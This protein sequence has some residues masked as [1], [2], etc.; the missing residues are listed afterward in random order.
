[1][2]TLKA[3]AR[4]NRGLRRKKAVRRR[5][6]VKKYQV[7]PPNPTDRQVGKLAATG[8]ECNCVGCQSG[9]HS[10]SISSVRANAQFVDQCSDL[11]DAD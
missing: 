5:N 2:D 3:E 6:S 10:K 1:M 8:K 7:L 9:D 4:G 11:Y